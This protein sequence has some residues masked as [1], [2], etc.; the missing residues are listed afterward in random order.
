MKKRVAA[1]A[2]LLLTGCAVSQTPKDLMES[3]TQT[4]HALKSNPLEA[5]WCMARN[6]ENWRPTSIGATLHPQVRPLANGQELIVTAATLDPTVVV[7]ARV[8]PLPPGSEATVWLTTRPI[9]H[10]RA[11]TRKALLEGC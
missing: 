2:L 10:G 9:I 4:T 11:A 6:I 7:V 3:G 1:A 8:M 5:A